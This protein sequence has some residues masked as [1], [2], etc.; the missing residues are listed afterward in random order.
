MASRISGER[1]P[2]SRRVRGCRV[3]TT[4]LTARV[5]LVNQ[6]RSTPEIEWTV[7]SGDSYDEPPDGV[8]VQVVPI[9]REFAWS[10]IGSFL[11]LW[12]YLRRQRF[13]FVQ[14][15]TP[16]ASFLGLPAARLAGSHAIYTIH[17]A[18]Y[19]E[20]NGRRANILG[21]CFERWC[22]TWANTVLL[23]SREDERTLPPARICRRG[24]L[25]FVGNGIMMERFLAPMAPAL[26][27][28]RPIVMTV[29]RLVREK[30]CSDFLAMAS[31]LSGQAEFIHVGPFEHDQ[32]D[33]MTEEEAAAV[34]ASGIVRFLGEVDDVRP[35]LASATVVV[36][37]SYREGIPRVAME[38]A[39]M[40]RTVAA[41]DIRGMREVI[42]PGLGLLVT[43]GDQQALTNV[44][45]GLLRE[46][47]RCA[48][49]G[50]LCR[51]WVLD[52]FSE[53]DVVG[54]L[55]ATYATIAGSAA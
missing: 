42:D 6:L 12:W 49:L 22:C 15:H 31:A 17:G 1:L 5:L 20:D 44:V 36:L 39:A 40:G 46:P 38:A 23:Q 54:R 9:R 2:P 34:S 52:R 8:A 14:T 21:W 3:V 50:D 35:Y 47:A 28:D 24:K 29:G 11:R 51:R 13:D 33:A 43:R 27:S 32:R 45:E 4:S 16:K 19:F 25:D 18:L 48:E 30:G 37:P 26:T 53:D 10:D 55:R 41:Y 7:V